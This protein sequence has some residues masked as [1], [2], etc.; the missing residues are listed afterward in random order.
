[1]GNRNNDIRVS[2]T[3]ADTY[4][5][6]VTRNTYNIVLARN[7]VASDDP[8][9]K[10]KILAGEGATNSM[11]CKL[12]RIHFK[13]GRSSHVLLAGPNIGKY[14]YS[15]NLGWSPYMPP[16]VSGSEGPFVDARNE[17]AVKIRQKIRE[18]YNSFAGASFL[19]EARDALH[20]IRHPAEAM[21]NLTHNFAKKNRKHRGK[22]G[23]AFQKAI[24]GS[25]LELQFG[26][27]PLADDVSSI[28]DSFLARYVEPKTVHIKAMGRGES[29]SSG[30]S[31]NGGT[32][33]LLDYAEDQ[34][35]K[36]WVL[37]HAGVARQIDTD[38]GDFNS[39]RNRLGLTSSDIIP[40]I[41][42]ALPWSFFIDYFSNV[43]D[44]LSASMVSTA[45]VKWAFT[46]TRSIKTFERKIL[47]VRG[48]DTTQIGSCKMISAPA[49]LASRTKVVRAAGDLPFPVLRFSLPVSTKK[50]ANLAALAAIVF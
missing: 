8:Y 12:D 28:A 39:L 4:F 35:L 32:D 24:G 48:R 21:F 19:A 42:E 49:H 25:W 47:R 2:Y 15:T 11:T 7:R 27:L 38:K 17:A 29:S 46:T 31:V 30:V 5:G 50:F 43:G 18:E 14:E 33:I 9:W 20:Q 10:Q 26:L 44:I 13:S 16:E 40:A 41:W 3:L 1:M 6:S 34:T 22:T 36:V 45:N 23:K 37:S